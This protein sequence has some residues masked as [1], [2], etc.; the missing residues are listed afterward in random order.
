M[1]EAYERVRGGRLAFK[2]GELAT[3]DKAIDKKR[4]KKKSK[5]KLQ[6]DAV[7]PEDPSVSVVDTGPDASDVYTIDP[8]KKM[9]YDELFP[10]E[11]KK[12]RYDPKAKATSVEEALDDRVK[13]KADRYC[14]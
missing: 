5:S 13:K 1:S 9:K 14:K 2:G 7:P 10:V 6:D 12:F 4:K 3:R 8:M 11:T